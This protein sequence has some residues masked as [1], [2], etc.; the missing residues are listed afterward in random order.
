MSPDEKERLR[1]N[2]QKK[3]DDINNEY[4]KFAHHRDFFYTKKTK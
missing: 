1:E 2:L 3:F 4:Q